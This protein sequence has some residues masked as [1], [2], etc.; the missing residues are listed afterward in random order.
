MYQHEIPA[1]R[2][3]RNKTPI[4]LLKPKNDE[5]KP[6]TMAIAKQNSDATNAFPLDG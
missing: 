1:T 4:P 2:K 6:A 3:R 5:H